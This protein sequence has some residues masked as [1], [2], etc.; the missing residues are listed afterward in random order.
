MDI[1]KVAIGTV[2]QLYGKF[3]VVTAD[4]YY[5]HLHNIHKAEVLEMAAATKTEIGAGAMRDAIFIKQGTIAPLKKVN[6]NT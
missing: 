5:C 4:Y 1:T 6:K 2:F 3:Y